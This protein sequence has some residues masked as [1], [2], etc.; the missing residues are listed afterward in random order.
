MKKKANI[1]M[2]SS[3]SSLG[4]GTKH[5]FML[6]KNLKKFFKIYYAIPKNKN[7]RKLL[8][9]QNHLVISERRISFLDI[10]RLSKFVRS[11]SIDII[12]AHGKGAGAIARILVILNKKKLVYTFHGIHLKCHSFIQKIIYI[13]YEF[14]LGRIDSTKVLVS[15]SEKEYARKSKI[16]LGKNNIVINNGVK[17]MPNKYSRIIKNESKTNSGSSKIKVV[18]VCRFVH[19]KNIVD[20]LKIAN[21]IPDVDFSIVGDGPL[22][23]EIKDFILKNNLKNVELI[24]KRKKVFDYLYNSDIY[25]STSLYEGL[26]LSILE[27]MSIGLPIVASNVTGNCDTII[28]GKSGYLYDSKDIKCAIECINKLSRNKKLR[29]NMGNLAYERQRA[30]FS[31]KLMIYKYANLYMKQKL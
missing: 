24:G 16:F 21:K 1:L 25:L 14:F 27:A 30:L 10:I 7:F 13:I 3:S 18:S 5:M 17:N 19:Q 26:P 6:G 28:N 23:S 22:M 15:E 20:I 31:K 11:K 4:G 2:I 29:I 12:H 9:D 8:N